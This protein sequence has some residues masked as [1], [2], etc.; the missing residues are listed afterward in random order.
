MS[1]P[2]KKS[3]F[4]APLRL[5]ITARTMPLSSVHFFPSSFTV[6]G[7]LTADCS[8]DGAARKAGMTK[9]PETSA[10]TRNRPG[11]TERK[12]FMR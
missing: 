4:I 1:S 8:T 7:I 3:E 6:T 11:R 9:N 5:S 12:N 2:L 10:V